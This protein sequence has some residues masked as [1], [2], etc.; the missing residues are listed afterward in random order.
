MGSGRSSAATGKS[1]SNTAGSIYY[2]GKSE[3]DE[4][5]G[6]WLESRDSMKS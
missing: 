4:H 1:K 6:D 2:Q 3:A 5:R